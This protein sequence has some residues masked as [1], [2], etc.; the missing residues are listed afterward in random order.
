MLACKFLAFFAA[1]SRWLGV[2]SGEVLGL[3]DAAALA[4]VLVSLIRLLQARRPT[5]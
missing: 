5:E 3:L 2:A 1:F 4:A